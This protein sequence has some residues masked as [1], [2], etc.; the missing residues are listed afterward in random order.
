M[1]RFTKTNSNITIIIFT[2][3]IPDI[4]P[5]MPIDNTKVCTVIN[6]NTDEA[7]KA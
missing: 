7:K 1:L 5:T 2:I 4:T 3:N 6:V